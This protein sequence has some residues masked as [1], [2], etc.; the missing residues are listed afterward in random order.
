MA[1]L[2]R[3]LA[4]KPVTVTRER[5]IES[6]RFDLY[7]ALLSLWVIVGLFVDG[8][9]HNHGAVDDTFFTPYHALLYSGILAVGLFLGITQYRNI[10]K[11]HSFS[12]A[13]PYGYNL[14]L[15]GVGLF[16]A[17][18]GFDFLWHSLF[19][20]EASLATLLSP[21]HL[22][23]ATAG[24]LIMSGPLRAA[25]QRT[26][27]PSTWANLLPVVVSLLLLLSVLTFFT[28][29]SNSF[30][31]AWGYVENVPSNERGYVDVLGVANILFPTTLMIGVLLFA[32][33]RWVLPFGAVTF[34]LLVNAAGMLALE[35]REMQQFGYV[36]FAA[37]AAGVVGD[38]LLRLL[39][40]TPANPLA[41][42]IFAF[43]VP[44]VISLVYFLLLITQVGIWWEIHK[45]LGVSF[46]AGASGLFLSY[47]ALPPALP[48]KTEG[49]GA[50]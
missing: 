5:P 21:A 13:L 7:V 14:S 23:L 47:L 28:Q 33:R 3:S 27:L 36:L 6:V 37:L 25:W 45:W 20:F 46:F 41:L 17:G 19:G 26:D 43:A 24:L 38:L 35:W 48:E 40:P 34:I 32:V 30:S 8:Y 4:S 18:G 16:F 29:F 44:F 42:R 15:V 11:G 1:T 22:L 50:I 31:R 2:N 10:A 49:T 39:K 9:A 12:R